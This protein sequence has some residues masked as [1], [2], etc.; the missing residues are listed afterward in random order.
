MTTESDAPVIDPANP[1]N[2][3]EIQYLHSQWKMPPIRPGDMVMWYKGK[4]PNSSGLPATVLK[5]MKGTKKVQ[6]WVFGDISQGGPMKDGVQHV[7]D[8]TLQKPGVTDNEVS[9]WEYTR[10]HKD[11]VAKV[12]E[13]DEKIIDLEKRLL[14]VTDKSA[15]RTSK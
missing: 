8:P 2:N 1:R 11:L 13:L 12:Q 14:T 10:Y 6:L 15:A 9:C 7:D 4:R 3:S 5:V